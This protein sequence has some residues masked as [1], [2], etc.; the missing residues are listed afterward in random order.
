MKPPSTATLPAASTG[1]TRPRALSQVSIMSGAAMVCSASVTSTV[2]ASIQSLGI[3]RSA[4]AAATMRLLASSPT[5]RTA[6][7]ERGDTSRSTASAWIRP[8]NSSSSRRRS[9]SS[10][11]RLSLVTAVATATC[12][13][14]SARNSDAAR[15]AAPSSASCA[16]ATSVSVTPASADTTTTG[17][18]DGVAR[19]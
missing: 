19:S 5:A 17:G 8:L 11:V 15:S 13:S 14:T 4:I 7:R 18:A 3:P 9:A 1:A 16:V 12:R 6:S 10:R 2:R